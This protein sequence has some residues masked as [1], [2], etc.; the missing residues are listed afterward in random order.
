MTPCVAFEDRLID[1]GDLRPGD[2]AVVDEHVA[3]CPACREYLA[4]L[5]EIDTKLTAD[6]RAIQLN[7]ERYAEVRRQTESVRPV[8][9]SSR[10]PE[11]LDFVAACAVCAFG[12]GL[13]WHSGVIAYLISTLSS[14][15]N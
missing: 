6:V 1:Y 2:G 5:K 10:L 13:A 15:P 12:Y 7:P 11:W 4:T 14:S 9:R 3:G 8:V